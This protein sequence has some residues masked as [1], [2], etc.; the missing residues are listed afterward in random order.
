MDR[1]QGEPIREGPWKDTILSLSG[2][3]ERA[4][5]RV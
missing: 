5:P 4:R 2:K 3:M 1:A